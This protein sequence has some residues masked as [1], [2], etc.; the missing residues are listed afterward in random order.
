MSHKIQYLLRIKFYNGEFKGFRKGTDIDAT[1][2]N[3][4][5]SL[6]NVNNILGRLTQDANII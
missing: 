2:A 3:S 1:N 6:V 5:G 4:I